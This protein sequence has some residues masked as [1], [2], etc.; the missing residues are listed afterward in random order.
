MRVLVCGGRTYGERVI[1][2]GPD[3]EPDRERAQIEKATL[4]AV[5]SKFH[6]EAK[7]DVLIE[8]GAKGADKWA[9]LWAKDKGVATESYEADWGAHGT[10]AGPMRNKIMLEEGRPDLVIAFPGGSGTRDMVRKARKAGV[11]V[12]EI[13]P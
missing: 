13:A 8:G 4:Y 5:L 9:A 12:V 10:F 7:I 2:S 11:D 1:L 3:A 6:A